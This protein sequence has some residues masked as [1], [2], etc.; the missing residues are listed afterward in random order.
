MADPLSASFRAS[1]SGLTAQSLRMRVAAENIANSMVTGKSPGAL[2]YA[3]K[4]VA[5]TETLDDV[6]GA[7]LVTIDA[8]DRDRSVRVERRPGHPAAD[9]QGLVK[10]PNVDP[11]IEMADMREAHRS[12]LANLQ[13]IRQARETISA[14]IDLLRGS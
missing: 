1:M 4:T 2:P 11:L 6:G 9:E 10:V 3:R 7:N 8:I 13:M 12:Y 5:F 14:T